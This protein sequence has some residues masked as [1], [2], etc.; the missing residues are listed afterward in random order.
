MRFVFARLWAPALLGTYAT[1]RSTRA[2]AQTSTAYCLSI[3]M[4]LDQLPPSG[5]QA[6]SHIGRTALRRHVGRQKGS[7]ARLL[8]TKLAGGRRPDNT[9]VLY[10][11]CIIIRIIRNTRQFPPYYRTLITA[12]RRYVHAICACLHCHVPHP[13]PCT[14]PCPE[15]WGKGRLCEYSMYSLN[16]RSGRIFFASGED[17]TSK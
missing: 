5:R 15:E 10:M 3:Y 7:H 4:Q 6:R 1:L 13:R 17:Y 14:G 11:Y 12:S 9:A 16:S 8:K 2:L